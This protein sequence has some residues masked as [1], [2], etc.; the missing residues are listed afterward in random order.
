LIVLISGGGSALLPAPIDPIT[1]D[2]KLQ[3]IK[4]LSNAGASI[5]VK[6]YMLAKMTHVL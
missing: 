2:E 3:V 6:N 1:L 5:Q 4:N